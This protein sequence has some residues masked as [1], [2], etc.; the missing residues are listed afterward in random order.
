MITLKPVGGR[1]GGPYR[2]VDQSLILVGLCG[3][4]GIHDIPK[5][6]KRDEPHERVPKG[7]Y[8]KKQKKKKGEEEEGMVTYSLSILVKFSCEPAIFAVVPILER[9]IRVGEAL[10]GGEKNVTTQTHAMNTTSHC[11]SFSPASSTRSKS[12]TFC[13]NFPLAWAGKSSAGVTRRPTSQTRE[14]VGDAMSSWR[15]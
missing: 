6:N 8:G 2:E 7:K 10:E 5:Q 4:C 15:R 12:M 9:K 1:G 3:I 13:S 11:P 14:N